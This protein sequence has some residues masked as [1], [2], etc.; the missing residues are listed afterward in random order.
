MRDAVEGCKEQYHVVSQVLPQEQKHYD[1]LCIGGLEPV[2]LLGR[3]K[4]LG[5]YT[6]NNAVIT[7]EYLPDKND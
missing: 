3:V 6:V 4:D 1:N 2:Y 5:C 7:E